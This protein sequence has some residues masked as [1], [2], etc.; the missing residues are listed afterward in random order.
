MQFPK[1][2]GA[3]RERIDCV[4]SAAI[5]PET[6]GL[7]VSHALLRYRVRSSPKSGVYIQRIAAAGENSAGQLGLGFLSKDPTQGLV[8][9]SGG[10]SDL[11]GQITGLAGCRQ[12]S[13]AVVTGEHEARIYRFG[14]LGIAGGTS[15]V[16]VPTEM[17]IPGKIATV[18]SMA[19]GMDHAVFAISREK[20]SNSTEVW[21]VGVGQDGQLG[22]G[23]VEDSNIAERVV[24]L[25]MHNIKLLASSTDFTLALTQEGAVLGW[26]NCEYGQLAIGRV[27]DRIIAPV[28]L[29]FGGINVKDIAAGG[30]FMVIVSASGDMYTSGYGILGTEADTSYRLQRVP[31]EFRAEACYATTDYAA[32][33][34]NYGNLY[35]FGLNNQY[36][37]LGLGHWNNIQKP[38]L[39]TTEQNI[40]WNTVNLS[41]WGMLLTAET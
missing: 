2:L 15:A 10:M 33:K 9:M 17:K 6:I 37:R 4:D 24:G 35:T 25:E 19:S 21:S 36:G 27:E 28:Q 32:V 7:G 40:K 39:V 41:H 1:L 38:T 16:T 11:A 18:V 30:T 13:F 14:K 31:L 34:D 22:N 3:V 23:K 20:D 29:D 8:D 5:I 12:G 26:G